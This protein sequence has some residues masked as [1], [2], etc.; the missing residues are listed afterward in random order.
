MDKNK[1]ISF[2]CDGYSVIVTSRRISSDVV[3]KN[4][5]KQFILQFGSIFSTISIPYGCLG[6]NSVDGVFG[7]SEQ[8]PCQHLPK[9]F[10]AKEMLVLQSPIKLAVSQ[11][12]KN[13]II[14]YLGKKGYHMVPSTSKS[15]CF[16]PQ[17][18]CNTPPFGVIVDAVIESCGNYFHL[19]NY[20]MRH[21][22]HSE[23]IGPTDILFEEISK[24]RQ[25]RHMNVDI[26]QIDIAV[27]IPFPKGRAIQIEITK[28]DAH[29]RREDCNAVFSKAD[30][31]TYPMHCIKLSTVKH[32][33][34]S[35]SQVI[36]A[37]NQAGTIRLKYGSNKWGVLNHDWEVS[38]EDIKE[39]Y[40][41]SNRE[42]N[43]EDIC[44]SPELQM[45]CNN[46][47]SI[48]GY[49]NEAHS[50]RQRRSQV[51]LTPQEMNHIQNKSA[52]ALKAML[53]NLETSTMFSF[54]NVNTFGVSARLEV[55]IR[56]AHHDGEDQNVGLLRRK[57]HFVD[58][59]AH[60]CIGLEDCVAGTFLL[61]IKKSYQDSHVDV[62][63]SRFQKCI[64]QL[65]AYTSIRNT[66]RFCEEWSHVK[67]HVWFR[68]MISLAMTIAGYATCYKTKYISAWLKSKFSESHAF[69]DPFNM[70][71]NLEQPELSG[72]SNYEQGQV[73]KAITEYQNDK[74]YDSIAEKSGLSVE[75]K[76]TMKTYMNAMNLKRFCNTDNKMDKEE[77]VLEYYRRFNGS[78]K[79]IMLRMP[80]FI[81]QLANPSSNGEEVEDIFQVK[82]NKED[83]D[84]LSTE[85][86]IQEQTVDHEDNSGDTSFDAIVPPS[87]TNCID[88][89]IQSLNYMGNTILKHPLDRSFINM[90]RIHISNCHELGLTLKN[91]EK[92]S[93]LR[94]STT[95]RDRQ[96]HDLLTKDIQ[97]Y[98]QI[99]SYE[100]LKSLCKI[101]Q[102]KPTTGPGGSMSKIRYIQCLCI[103]YSFPCEGINLESELFQ[104]DDINKSIND[105]ISRVISNT[106]EC[107]DIGVI[108]NGSNVPTPAS[109][110]RRRTLY[111]LTGGAN[112][113]SC[114]RLSDHPEC[115][116]QRLSKRVT[117]IDSG[118]ICLIKIM[119]QFGIEVENVTPLSLKAQLSQYYTEQ[120][121][122]NDFKES[123]SEETV[124]T[125]FMNHTKEMVSQ[126][127]LSQDEVM[128]HKIVCPIFTK[129]FH[130]SISVWYYDHSHGSHSDMFEYLPNHNNTVMYHYKK[131]YVHVHSPNTFQYMVFSKTHHSL[132]YSWF[133]KANVQQEGN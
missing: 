127:I 125:I 33:N 51:P 78:D 77:T 93:S 128:D 76:D 85:E 6:S 18:S 113:T 26:A 105:A 12:C 100:D 95:D 74:W 81:M 121:E 84:F 103:H 82:P 118:Y 21:L 108:D 46:Y 104:S 56:P 87:N 115:T 23:F 19:A 133:K 111:F 67:Y 112:F 117:D 60:A 120:C 71:N 9:E 10:Q 16:D 90:M 17:H 49:S 63:R 53:K 69:H 2:D 32:D 73:Y 68:A 75:G 48:K 28:N 91:N 5:S 22:I 123:A 109:P 58:F 114:Q 92:L 14:E 62:L 107:T 41:S 132:R 25:N 65:K 94:D 1:E 64:L 27:N 44:K 52:K 3:V 116:Q 130:I 11:E 31:E 72:L 101:L 40:L 20:G 66:T 98:H 126:K 36:K 122:L 124:Y 15:V 24:L 96:A 106:G 80:S 110:K 61:K 55:S 129:L 39:I 37:N 38:N 97:P 42:D 86:L 88:S 50:L 131:G 70:S 7:C 57:G 59:L 83:G 29:D 79:I 30:M 102:V 8:K 43:E 89:T 45:N 47:H 4:L 54:G 35:S 34:N 13:T 119:D 99:Y